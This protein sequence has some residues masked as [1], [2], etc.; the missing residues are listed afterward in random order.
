MSY[1]ICPMSYV[2]CPMSYVI[3]FGPLCP[4]MKFETEEEAIQMANDTE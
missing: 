3:A 2:I 4:L 1:V